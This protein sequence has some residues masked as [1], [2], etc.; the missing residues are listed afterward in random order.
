M[1]SKLKDQLDFYEEF[2]DYYFQIIND[3]KFSYQ[4]DYEARNYLSLL[5]SKKSQNWSLDEILY[6]FRDRISSKEAVLV[7]GCGPSLEETVDSILKS[8]GL[9]YFNKF[10]NLAADGAS[11][12]LKEKRIKVDAIF[13]DLDGI[14]KNEFENSTFIVVHAH[15]DNIKLLEYFKNEII[16]FKYIIGTTQVEPAE[17]LINSGG[18]TDG[19]RVLY[20]IRPL[21]T[22]VQKIFLIG[23]DFGKITGRYSKLDIKKNQIASPEKIKKLKYALK[24]IK[25]LTDKIYNAIYFVNSDFDSGDIVNVSIE[26]FLKL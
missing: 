25:G 20:F 7:Y 2:K 12:L 24:L 4:K 21:L 1:D 5:L 8:K 11:V 23:M 19:D 18:F 3:F 17:N 14:T 9:N 13:T 15:G 6:Q 16:N 10:I 22:S 26:E